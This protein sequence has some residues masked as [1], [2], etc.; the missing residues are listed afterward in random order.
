MWDKIKEKFLNKK[1]LTF[2]IIGAFNTVFCLLVNHILIALGLEVGA[3]SILS[4]AIAMIPSYMLNM[5][6]TYH[7]EMSWKS[8]VTFPLSYVP[9]WIISFLIVEMLHRGLGVPEQWAKLVSVPIYIPVNF[10]CMSF[11]VGKF[12]KKKEPADGQLQEEGSA[13]GK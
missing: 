10:L 6:F 8:F 9:G 3:A 4:D 1:F 11:I 7:Q 13:K 12:G 5:H 2:G